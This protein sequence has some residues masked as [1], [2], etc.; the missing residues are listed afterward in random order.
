M[1]YIYIYTNR[2][3]GKQYVGQTTNS[4]NERQHKHLTEV[5]HPKYKSVFHDAI[6]KYGIE[7]FNREVIKVDKAMLDTYEIDLIA[8]WDTKVPNGYNILSGGG[9]M[10]GHKHTDEWKREASERNTG[11]KNAMYG[12]KCSK[13]T[14]KLMSKAHKGRIV[15]DD[16]RGLMSKNQWQRKSIIVTVPGGK[17]R[18]FNSI[19]DAA[20]YY[21]L[22]HGGFSKVVTGQRK[23]YRGYTAQYT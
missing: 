8:R 17:Q 4:I 16:T 1:A 15:S 12:R 13:E 3:N 7:N 9:G 10:R 21:G 20:R 14:R 23:Q 11:S 22:L 6:R 19:T 2:I 5:R 18:E